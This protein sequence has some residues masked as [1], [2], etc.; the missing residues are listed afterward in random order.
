MFRNK[1]TD[2]YKLSFLLTGSHIRVKLWES[3][4]IRHV[5]V[6]WPVLEIQVLNQ[7]LDQEFTKFHCQ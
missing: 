2:S 1:K 5:N 4:I 6:T 7:D 3:H